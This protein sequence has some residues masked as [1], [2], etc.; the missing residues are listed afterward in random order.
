MCDA[1]ALRVNV[2]FV[3]GGTHFNTGVVQEIPALF[4]DLT[5]VTIVWALCAAYVTL[6]AEEI[7]GQ[8]NI[9]LSSLQRALIKARG[10]RLIEFE[11]SATFRAVESI[12][13]GAR[14]TITITWFTE[15]ELSKFVF[16]SVYF[17]FD[18][19]HTDIW[20]ANISALIVCQIEEQSIITTGASSCRS[21]TSRTVFI[22]SVA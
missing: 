11:I 21:L 3:S 22:T 10:R 14:S 1:R 17:W 18:C 16:L 9:Q 13:T 8:W 7:F 15:F 5:V 6:N 19:C 20:C 12:I 2:Y 4:T